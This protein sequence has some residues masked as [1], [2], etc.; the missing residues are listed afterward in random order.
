[1]H[2]SKSRRAPWRYSLRH[3]L[4]G[5]TLVAICLGL[6]TRFELR[7]WREHW[8]ADEIRRLGGMVEFREV[9]TTWLPQRYRQHV[10]SVYL[11][12]HEDDPFADHPVA[13]P[14]PFLAVP[15][16]HLLASFPQLEEVHFHSLPLQATDLAFI[17]RK[18]QIR[19]LTFACSSIDELS[20]LRRFP[21]LEALDLSSA[22][23]DDS[24]LGPLRELKQLETLDLS[25]TQITDAALATIGELPNLARLDLRDTKII[26]TNWEPLAS[27]L[28]LRQLN[29]SGPIVIFEGFLERRKLGLRDLPS[30]PRLESLWL[31]NTW[32]DDQSV[33]AIAKQRWLRLLDVNGSNVSDDKLTHLTKLPLT[34]LMVSETMVTDQ[35]LV[36][37]A[38]IKTLESLHMEKLSITHQGLASLASLPALQ[39]LYLRGLP[40]EPSPIP[41]LI[42]LQHLE[43]LECSDADWT[44]QEHTQLE[45]LPKLRSMYTRMGGWG[46]IEPLSTNCFFNAD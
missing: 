23:I 43:H 21:N 42:K 22:K 10:T 25:G 45:S 39:R 34:E 38:K 36:M 32:L 33:A 7:C 13:P 4:F 9:G 26:G 12:A 11:S 30:L 18:S 44:D 3:L 5:M 16:N 41:S 6:W 17:P 28:H 40:A 46:R 24:D 27:C 37:I 1:M 29:L 2:V 20:E 35:G 8:A 31:E 15:W 19:E 14:E